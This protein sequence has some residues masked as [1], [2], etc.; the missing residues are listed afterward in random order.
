[1]I[2][3]RGF[4][5]FEV[6]FAMAVLVFILGQLILYMGENRQGISMNKESI[7]AQA[8]ANELTEQLLSIPF[9]DLP[10]GTFTNDQIIDKQGIPGATK[11]P[12]RVGTGDFDRSFSISTCTKNDMVL[13][14]ILAVEIAWPPKIQGKSQKV[15]KISTIYAK[16]G[17]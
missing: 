1:M 13:Y 17:M 2:K 8:A 6:M 12:F 11:W 9:K 16:D 14:K 5:L 10:D 7:V 15:L 3:R 4:T